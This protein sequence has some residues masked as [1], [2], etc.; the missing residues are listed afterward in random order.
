ML[1]EG[2]SLGLPRRLP[3]STLSYLVVAIEPEIERPTGCKDVD[4]PRNGITGVLDAV[5]FVRFEPGRIELLE[6]HRIVIG[7]DREFA[8]EDDTHLFVFV[9]VHWRR[10][11]GG[12][13]EPLEGALVT[14]GERD[15][16]PA[17]FRFGTLCFIEGYCFHCVRSFSI[18][19]G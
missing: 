11:A 16:L 13:R 18:E 5:W 12:F 3:S 6:R 2:R 10:M 7:V 14:P 19:G 15:P 1:K 17:G 9:V 8:I 4:P